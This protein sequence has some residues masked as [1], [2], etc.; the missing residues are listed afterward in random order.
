MASLGWLA[1]AAW[2][3]DGTGGPNAGSRRKGRGASSVQRRRIERAV[4]AQTSEKLVKR[5]ETLVRSK[6]AESP[7]FPRFGESA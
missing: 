7:R 1:L 6:C 4:G 5:Q 3:G 2:P